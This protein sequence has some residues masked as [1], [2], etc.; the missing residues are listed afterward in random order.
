MQEK[1]TIKRIY[2]LEEFS[3][4]IGKPRGFRLTDVR[5]LEEEQRKIGVSFATAEAEEE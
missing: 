2:D 3:R 1:T 4:I 5:I